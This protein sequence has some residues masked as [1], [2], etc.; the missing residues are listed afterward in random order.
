M[1]YLK[2]F[3][4]LF[5][6]LSINACCIKKNDKI[7][8]KEETTKMEAQVSEK[9]IQEGYSKAYIVYNKEKSATC[10]YLIQVEGKTLIEPRLALKTDF[11][12]EKLKIWVK[13][14]PQ[15][16]MSRCGKAQ[17]VE[18]INIEKR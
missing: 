5:L 14:H 9:M 15:R 11:Q 12:V 8:I 13:Y 10:K 2:S 1:N 3:F 4:I 7:N 18:I 6:L 16:R 17:P